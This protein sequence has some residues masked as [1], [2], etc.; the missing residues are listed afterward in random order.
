MK[1][2]GYYLDFAKRVYVYQKEH[3]LRSDG[4]YDG[5]MGGASSG[6]ILYEIVN[7]VKYRRNT[8][9]P[10]RAGPAITYNSGTMLSG[11]ADLY[12]VTG[13]SKYLQDAKDM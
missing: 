12:R 10:D 9:L 13:D 2:G 7:G 1:K 8:H 4:V 11:A 3:L 5:M 6:E